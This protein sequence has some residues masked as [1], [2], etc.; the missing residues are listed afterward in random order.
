MA[1]RVFT[2]AELE[3]LRAFPEINPAELIR[4]FTLT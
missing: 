4:F 1:T 2:D 3:R